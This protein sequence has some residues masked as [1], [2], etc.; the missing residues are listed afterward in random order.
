MNEVD[1]LLEELDEMRRVMLSRVK[2]E[3][4]DCGCPSGR[5]PADVASVT[6]LR[7]VQRLDIAIGEWNEK[8]HNKS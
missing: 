2:W 5:T 1:S 6:W 4:C 8:R 7:A 3:Q